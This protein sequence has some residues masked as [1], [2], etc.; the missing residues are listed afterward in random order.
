MPAALKL[1]FSELPV[2]SILL[3]LSF[4]TITLSAVLTVGAVCIVHSRAQTLSNKSDTFKFRT[5]DTLTAVERELVE[6]SKQAI[7]NTGLSDPYF[8]AHFTLLQVVN[9]AAD[10][11]VTWQLSIQ[12][13]RAVVKD[14]IG[15]YTEGPNRIH[16]HSVT[17]ALGQTSE[18]VKTIPRTRALKIMKTCI[19][20]FSFPVV[21][22]GPVDGHAEL[23]M[24]AHSRLPHEAAEVR[25][26]KGAERSKHSKELGAVDEIESEG[27]EKNRRKLIM[28]FVNLQTGRCTKGAGVI[29]P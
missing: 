6:G 7:I 17:Q 18:I 21:E 26:R 28:G 14:S 5:L 27:D 22:Y 9:K 2:M 24:V 16:T 15:F 12:G 3:N 29:A 23:L 13:H 11:R 8:R 19:G 4:S 25:E 1:V 10:R 20:T